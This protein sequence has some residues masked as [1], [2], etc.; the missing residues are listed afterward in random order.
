MRKVKRA[1]AYVIVNFNSEFVVTDRYDNNLSIIH[2]RN[3]NVV[4]KARIMFS[5]S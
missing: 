5:H 2:K 1:H 3:I 4:I